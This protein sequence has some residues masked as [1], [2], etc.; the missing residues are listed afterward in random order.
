ME[1][2]VVVVCGAALRHAH[3]AEKTPKSQAKE[4]TWEGS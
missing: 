4:E 3:R 1:Q 2:P